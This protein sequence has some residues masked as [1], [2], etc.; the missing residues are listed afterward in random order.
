[1]IWLH[2]SLL[3]VE[4][5]GIEPLTSYNI[6]AVKGTAA[7]RAFCRLKAEAVE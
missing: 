5:S 1:M 2:K 7:S 4:I 6:V 3:V